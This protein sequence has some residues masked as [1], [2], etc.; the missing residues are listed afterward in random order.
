M[1]FK[2]RTSWRCGRCAAE[3]SVKDG[4]GRGRGGPGQVPGREA[5]R[6]GRGTG[7]GPGGKGS[8]GGVPLKVPAPCAAGWP[9]LA[10]P[11]ESLGRV[12]PGTGGWVPGQRGGEPGRW[13][14]TVIHF[15]SLST[16][17]RCAGPLLRDPH[18]LLPGS[19]GGPPELVSTASPECDS[20]LHPGEVGWQ[21]DLMPHCRRCPFAVVV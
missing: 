16:P 17:R 8:E 9:A 4:A 10:L 15:C 19:A 18:S 12:T 7:P 13:D 5:H 21:S 2:R 1:S 11:A 6:G 3:T 14:G 20:N